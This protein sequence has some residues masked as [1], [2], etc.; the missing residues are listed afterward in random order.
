MGLGVPF[1]IA[2]YSLLT[3]IVAHFCGLKPGDFIH[4]M[5]DAHVYND[6]VD[7]LEEQLKRRPRKFPKLT[8]GREVDRIEDLNFDDFVLSGYNPHGTIKMKM[9]V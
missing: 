5:G 9:S 1:N 4:S 3:Y 7:A 2:S 6:H 8:I